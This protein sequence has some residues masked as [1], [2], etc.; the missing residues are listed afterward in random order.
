[1]VPFLVEMAADLD[2]QNKAG[3]T[4]LHIAARAKC[5]KCFSLLLKQGADLCVEDKQRLTPFHVLCSQGKEGLN[6]LRSVFEASSD[7]ERQRILDLKTSSDWSMSL[8]HKAAQM[9]SEIVCE[10]LLNNRP[11]MIHDQTE[12]VGHTPLHIAASNHHPG[13]CE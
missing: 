4:P 6:I 2:H 7:R 9:G 13:D 12:I 11:A 3:K 8:L 1:M 5:R 10:F